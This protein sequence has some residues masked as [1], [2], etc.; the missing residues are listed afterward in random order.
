[1][2]CEIIDHPVLAK[3]GKERYLSKCLNKSGMLLYSS[4]KLKS[5]AGVY[6]S[7]YTYFYARY[8]PVPSGAASSS[9]TR[10]SFYL[11]HMVEM[12]RTKMDAL[13]AQLQQASDK[14]TRKGACMWM[15]EHINHAISMHNGNAFEEL[16]A[17][18]HF[19]ELRV[20]RID[21]EIATIKN[22]R[23]YTA[24]DGHGTTTTSMLVKGWR[25]R[26]VVDAAHSSVSEVADQY[27]R[28]EWLYLQNEIRTRTP[29][30]AQVS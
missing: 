2:S 12:L 4:M 6:E 21:D 27:A 25:V 1:M 28:D 24:Y 15:L 14:A 26:L 30:L 29:H 9:D 8:E 7:L 5:P 20:P 3:D 10:D 18:P 11:K 19:N 22:P 23:K 16:G 13:Y 17:V